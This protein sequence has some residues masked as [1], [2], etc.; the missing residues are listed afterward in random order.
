MLSFLS[1]LFTTTT[2]A[3]TP[4]PNPCPANLPYGAPN[5]TEVATNVCHTGYYS[6]YDTKDKLPI[7][8]AWPLT[9]EH[10][11]GCI[12]RV[13]IFQ[14]DPLVTG[15]DTEPSYYNH[16]GFDRGHLADDADFGWSET[17][18]RES[19]YMTNMTPQVPGLNRGGWK[20]VETWSRV[21]ASDRGGLIIYA[22]P[23]L[24]VTDVK[25]SIDN[26]DVPARFWKVIY[27][28][29]TN[30]AAAFIMPNQKVT[31]DQ[32]PQLATSVS[33]VEQATGM[34]IPLPVSYDKKQA[35]DLSKWPVN[36]GKWNH[37]KMAHCAANINQ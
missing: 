12:G 35:T 23:I 17:E 20:T 14:H 22:G 4:I 21:W 1:I 29:K 16:S 27:D 6:A 32:V 28:P 5:L 9:S 3:A 34:N 33:A 8:V 13:G 26:I 36:L 18:S 37:D 11:M 2:L 31:A 30:E 24:N 7:F 19:F 25:F 10:A 15:L